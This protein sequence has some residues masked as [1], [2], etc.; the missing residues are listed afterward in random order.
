MRLGQ[1][2]RTIL[3]L[4]SASCCALLA[5][6]VFATVLI[7]ASL[8]ISRNEQLAQQRLRSV[9]VAQR[10]ERL[11]SEY[12]S[13]SG[14]LENLNVPTGDCAD[15]VPAPEKDGYITRVIGLDAL[16]ISPDQPPVYLHWCAVAW[17][18][19]YGRTGKSTFFVND[20][21]D[22]LIEQIPSH[23]LGRDID[24]EAMDDGALLRIIKRIWPDPL[25]LAMPNQP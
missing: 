2:R 25:R 15:T 24:F 6:T 18:S 10:Q 23:D 11:G 22:P 8:R 7:V 19:R 20:H 14:R 16:T 4:V 12:G 1:S 13:Y 17:P 21:C 5:V 3:A 9:I